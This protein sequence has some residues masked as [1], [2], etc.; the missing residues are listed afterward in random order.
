MF[1]KAIVAIAGLGL[2]SLMA[3]CATAPIAALAVAPVGPSPEGPGTGTAKGRVVV[4]SRLSV[5]TDDQ[6]QDSTYPS[7]HQHSDYYLCNAQGGVLKHVF[8]VAGHYS[9]EPRVVNL[10]AGRYIVEAQSAPDFW[11]KVPVV[12][13]RGETTEVHLDGNWAPPSYLDHSQLVTLPNGKPV[14]WGL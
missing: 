14:G 1:M 4:Y 2:I 6:S 12:V 10:P 7:W 13:K 3:G 9:R 5:R 8:N 11:V